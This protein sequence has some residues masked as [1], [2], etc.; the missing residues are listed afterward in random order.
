MK[1]S[2]YAILGM[3]RYGRKIASTI[4]N[5]GADVLIADIN[6]DIIDQYADKYTYAVSLDLS[7][8]RALSDIGLDHI[9]IVIIDL[10]HNMEAAL[11]CIMVAKENGVKKVISTA[12]TNRTAEIMKRV[13]ADEVIIPEDEAAIRM[14]KRL[15]SEDFMEMHDLGGD[16]CVIKVSPKKEWVGKSLRKLRLGEQEH[17]TVVAIEKDGKMSTD[18]D[19]DTVIFEDNM[20]ALALQKSK[21]YDFV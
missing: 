13:G 11:M 6:P 15:I 19:G 18:F 3:G 10:N 9:D 1:E 7:N 20:L 8:P 17:I 5:T 14:A 12:K 21:I 2:S 4:V 16:L